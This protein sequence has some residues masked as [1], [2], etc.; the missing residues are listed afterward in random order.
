MTRLRRAEQLG[1]VVTGAVLYTAV[2]AAFA[3]QRAST[4]ATAGE[5]NTT[6]HQPSL[7]LPNQRWPRVAAERR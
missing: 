5:S 7:A 4:Q 1:A 6:R 2:R 3:A